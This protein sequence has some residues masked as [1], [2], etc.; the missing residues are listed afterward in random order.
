MNSF[1]NSPVYGGILHRR[2]YSTG[3]VLREDN[4]PINGHLKVLHL[5]EVSSSRIISTCELKSA[6]CEASRDFNN[7]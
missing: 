2:N 4:F 5:E 7:P 1:M 3:E 6:L